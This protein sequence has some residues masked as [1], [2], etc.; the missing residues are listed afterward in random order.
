MDH[1]ILGPDEHRKELAR[2]LK[3]GG[4][5][6]PRGFLAHPDKQVGVGVQDVDVLCEQELLL[7]LVARHLHLPHFTVQEV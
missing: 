5:H 3:S 2:E 6:K 1:G 7:Q 4:A